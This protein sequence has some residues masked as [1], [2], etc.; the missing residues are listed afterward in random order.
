VASSTL[1]LSLIAFVCVFVLTILGGLVG[2]LLWEQRQT[3]DSPMQGMTRTDPLHDAVAPTPQAR[4]V[5]QPMPG[6]TVPDPAVGIAGLDNRPLAQPED[7][8][9]VDPESPTEIISRDT[10][11]QDQR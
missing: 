8:D 5:G 6:P 1:T 3:G 11:K 10:N 7:P 4:P 2:F 9:E